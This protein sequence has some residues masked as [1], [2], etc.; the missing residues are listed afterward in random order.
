MFQKMKL[1]AARLLR[2]LASKVE[3]RA[4]SKKEISDYFESAFFS[5]YFSE[6]CFPDGPPP[7]LRKISSNLYRERI[8]KGVGGPIAIVKKD[9]KCSSDM[10]EI[11]VTEDAEADK[12]DLPRRK[13]WGDLSNTPENLEKILDKKW[14]LS[15]TLEKIMD[16]NDAQKINAVVVAGTAS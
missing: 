3:R 10:I 4:W 13:K 9:K 11:W 7:S 16:K 5:A 6:E 12:P 1:W 14:D 8:L 15:N 2:K